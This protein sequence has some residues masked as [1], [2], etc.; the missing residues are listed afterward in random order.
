MKKY[1]LIR[2]FFLK[3]FVILHFIANVYTSFSHHVQIIAM[4]ATFAN[5]AEL[6][7]WLNAQQ[8]ETDFRPVELEEGILIGTTVCDVRTF[9]PLRTLP[10]RFEVPSDPERIVQ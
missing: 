7:E 4:S 5:L 8:F 3:G 1:L 2:A 9:Y 6:G 10:P